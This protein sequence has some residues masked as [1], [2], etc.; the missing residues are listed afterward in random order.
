MIADMKKIL[1]FASLTLLA[2]SAV[3]APAKTAAAPAKPAAT[4]AKTTAAPAKPAAASAKPD[5]AK[6]AAK[7]QDDGTCWAVTEAGTRCRHKKDGASDYCKQH[8][9]N[10]KPSKPLDRCRAL[11]WDGERCGRKPEEGFLYCPQ[12]RKLG[13]K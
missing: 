2:W 6:K 8:G 1:A 9:P 4:S 12:H 13:A 7:L 11:K 5:A 3:A 10:V